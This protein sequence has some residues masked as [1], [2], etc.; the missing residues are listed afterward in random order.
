MLALQSTYRHSE[1]IL[2]LISLMSASSMPSLCRQ[3]ALASVRERLKLGLSEREA[4]KHVD[5]LVHLSSSALVASFVERMH[6]I[7]QAI[8]T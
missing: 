1:L 7:A 8:R 4:V 3:G 6:Q 5:H 2:G